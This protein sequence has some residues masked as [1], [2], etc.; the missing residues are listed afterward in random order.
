MKRLHIFNPDQELALAFGK[1]GFT[2]PEAGRL[3]RRQLG[4][5]PALWADDGDWVW[6]DDVD[7]VTTKAK[8]LENHLAKV[9]YMSTAMLSKS[10]KHEGTIEV[11][12]WG[13]NAA[14]RS[15]L[16]RAGVEEHCLP[17][18]LQIRQIRQLSHRASS[19]AVLHDIVD[20]VSGTIGKRFE[21][22]TA[23]EVFALTQEMGRSGVRF[24]EGPLPDGLGGFVDSVLRR[25]GSIIIEPRYDNMQDFGM[26][27][28]A[29]GK[30]AARY[31]GIS[32]FDARH[33]YCARNACGRHWQRKWLTNKYDRLAATLQEVIGEL[34][35][36]LGAMCNGIYNGPLG[37]DMMVVN[38]Q[39][40]TLLHP[41]VEINVRRT[42]GHVA[43]AIDFASWIGIEARQGSY[44][45]HLEHDDYRKVP[46]L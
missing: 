1:E 15:Q 11:C 8:E 3:L 40:A 23:A 24:I 21:A 13:W 18:P 27:F 14:L 12:P 20:T 41:C 4:F 5:L 9:R 10:L 39:G 19:I 7:E 26:E 46:P 44:S 30:G 34:E 42:M 6:V 32:L 25:Q 45:L 37:V 36:C 43:L 38:S 2:A 35:R 29:D 28:I 16:L 22:H 33:G 31:A 17:S